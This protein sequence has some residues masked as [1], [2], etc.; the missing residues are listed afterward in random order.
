MGKN[1]PGTT[2]TSAVYRTIMRQPEIVQT[3][4]DTIAPEAERA[5]RNLIGAQRIF[6]TGTGTNSHAA[7]VGE[8]LLRS[9]GAEAFATT[10]FDFVT[11]PRVLSTTD[12]VIAL[13]HTGTTQYGRQAIARGID[14]GARTIGIT[15]LGVS[16]EGPDVVLQVGPKEESDT[17]TASYTA[18]LTALAMISVSF[19]MQKGRDMTALQDAIV[20]ASESIASLLE[21]KEAIV[22]LAES[23]ATRGRLVLAGAGPNA[24]TAREGALKVKESSYLVAEG[25][26]VETLLHGGLQAVEAGDLAVIIAPQGPALQR[27]CDAVR[28]LSIIGAQLIVV[29]DERVLA[30]LPN[31]EA[32]H[33]AF[34]AVPESLSPLLAVVPLQLLAAYTAHVRGTNPDNFRF[35]DAPYKRAIESLML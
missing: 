17:Y 4:I 7:V 31:V 9:A 35:D 23:L 12:A 34:P 22:R 5:A 28:A 1:E 19:G 27:A 24:V 33:I 29:A 32:T 6:L 20:S 15:A 21:G 8:H 16:M 3:V 25:F 18:T 2:P 14:A 11:Y 13:S 26:D 10:H 30:D